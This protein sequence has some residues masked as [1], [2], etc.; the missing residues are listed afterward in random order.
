MR[1]AV[2]E[3]NQHVFVLIFQSLSS[4][5]LHNDR[6]GGFGPSQKMHVDDAC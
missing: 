4:N 6:N 1:V 3:A 5:V 2:L